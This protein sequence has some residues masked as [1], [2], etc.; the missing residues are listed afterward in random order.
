MTEDRSQVTRDSNTDTDV[1]DGMTFDIFNANPDEEINI[2]ISAD[3]RLAEEAI[4]NFVEAYN[5]FQVEMQKQVGFN[6]EEGTE[7]ALRSD[8]MAR[9]LIQSVRSMISATVPEIGRAHV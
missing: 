2:N 7:G 9:N 1:I 8:S 3:H 6:V 5:T 4:R